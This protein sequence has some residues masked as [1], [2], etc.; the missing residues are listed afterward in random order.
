MAGLL[1]L[2]IYCV[3]LAERSIDEELL[4]ELF[5]Q[6]PASCLVLLED[7]DTAGLQKR[8][9]KIIKEESI[10][11]GENPEFKKTAGDGDTRV[12]LNGVTLSGLLNVIDGVASH[13]GRV[14]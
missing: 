10:G 13:E 6:L 14:L 11:Y 9:D 8:D 3:S 5:S 2:N 7:I 4:F 1:D 12:A